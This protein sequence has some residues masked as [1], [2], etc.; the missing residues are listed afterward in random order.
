MLTSHSVLERHLAAFNRHDTAGLMATLAED[1]TWRTG[2][3][4]IHGRAAVAELFDDW[5]WALNPSLT[6]LGSVA[7]SS[8][9]AAQ[10]VER[11]T[12][13]GELR[14]FVIAGFFEVDQGVIRVATIF[15]EGSADLI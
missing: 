9:V 1:V 15:R 8:M 5:L 6:L 10:L 12:L 4:T 3:D 13:D 2:R 11:L 14:Q 7:E